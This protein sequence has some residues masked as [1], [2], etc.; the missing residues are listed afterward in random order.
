MLADQLAASG[1]DVVWW[2]SAFDHHAKRMLFS[3]Q[4][5]IRVSQGVLVCA[6][7]GIGYRRNVSL[8]RYADH[9]VVARKFREAAR[10]RPTPDVIVTSVPDYN[11]AFEAVSYGRSRGIPVIADIRDGWPDVFLDV[12]PGWTRP[13]VRRLLWYDTRTLALTLAGA[14]A[15]TAITSGW[16][17]WGLAKA[18][19]TGTPQDR[20]FFLGARPLAAGVD[21]A[22]TDQVRWL[23]ERLAG[24]FVVT[25]IGTFGR[26]ADPRVL[27]RAA[28]LVGRADIGGRPV[29]IVLAGD[30]PLRAAVQEEV[31][32]LDHVVCPGWLDNDEI[33]ALLRLS[34]VG[35]VPVGVGLDQFPN[36]AFTYLSGGLPVL[37]AAVGDL[38]RLLVEYQAGLLFPAQDAGML[39]EHIEQLRREEQLYRRMMCNARQLFAERLDAKAIY[40]AFVEHIESLVASGGRWGSAGRA[41]RSIADPRLVG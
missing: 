39:A 4:E 6:L 8:R 29:V 10:R 28:R 32:G 11:L 14:D 18:G 27:A 17:E 16:L 13:L 3:D 25:F 24:R 15:L 21:R 19:R 23:R 26:S 33:E 30:G 36:K 41:S 2:T 34:S 35:V 22:S 20:V 38:S 40:A 9:L 5:E 1:H 31:A 12:V 7:R 37:T